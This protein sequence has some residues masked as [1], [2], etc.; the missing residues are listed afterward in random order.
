M[1]IAL[2]GNPNCGKSTLFNVL[3]GSNQRVGNWPGVT[4]ERK[5]G[6]GRIGTDLIEFIDLPG[7][8]S[9]ENDNSILSE[10]ERIASNFVLTDMDSLIINIIDA[11]NLR[12]SLYLTLQL[13]DLK[14]PM[15]IVL[16]MMDALKGMDETINL[17]MLS[18]LL[19]CPIV[20]ISATRKTGFELLQK[21]VGHTLKTLKVPNPHIETL[22]DR[23]LEQIATHLN[24]LNI[25]HPLRKLSRFS[26]VRY[27]LYSD[28]VPAALQP[29]LLNCR[30]ALIAS[31]KED[32]DVII[33]CSRYEAIEKVIQKVLEKRRQAGKTFTDKL[34]Y[35]ILGRISGIPLFFFSM[36]VM[37]FLAISV[38][39]VFNDFFEEISSIIFVD[40][41]TELLNKLHM[42]QGIILILAKGIGS[43][44]STVASFIPVIS[45][46]F[47]CL[48]FLEDSGYLARAAMVVDRGMRVIGLPGKA[49]VPMLVG[50][51]CSVPA[52]MGTRT[53]DNSRDRLMSICMIPFMSCGARLPVFTLFAVIFF[54]DHP[55]TTVFSL[56]ILGLIAAI[57]TGF[58]LKNTLLP[59]KITPFIM[60]LPA[61]RI[62]NFSALCK[63]TWIRLKS[64][65]FKAGKAII[66]MVTLLSILNSVSL[67]GNMQP[68]NPDQTVLA[69]FSQYATPVFEPIGITRE[70]WPATVGIFT[71]IFAKEAVIGTLNA[72]YS[73]QQDTD[74]NGF[75]WQKSIQDA[76][77]TIPDNFS[78]MI[79]AWKNN[80]IWHSTINQDEEK[81]EMSPT[82]LTKIEISFGSSSAAMAY[83]IFVLL[84]TPCVAALGA[85]YREA[86][87]RWAIFV[88]VWTFFLAWVIATAYYQYMQQSISGQA[89]EW[90]IG[91]TILMIAVIGLLCVMGKKGVMGIT[92]VSKPTNC[93]KGCC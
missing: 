44:I 5:L 7:I 26:L 4:V 17:N 2:I 82:A 38:S 63:L 20:G 21:V 27:L 57:F 71:G 31:Y 14:R 76:I 11:T 10:D 66:L 84:Y 52:V 24:V 60:E 62:P 32:I 3:T 68:E 56:Y 83:L 86:G 40:G 46:M 54:P 53:L 88:A 77:R 39:S 28:T 18:S 67:S 29:E 16:N 87:A 12:R 61:Y 49:F 59:G 75:E 34:D 81:E 1:N 19:G 55:S 47:F 80:F 48:S 58:I 72:L 6:Y 8:Y 73:I 22:D 91:L 23:T 78:D 9:L 65:L 90:L 69:R 41:L 64:F 35:F 89:I 79:T 30:N 43:G 93:S 51:G 45:A 15:I 42:P 50:F 70:N 92:T 13:L 74:D 37:F 25:A 33:A 36:Y 85:V